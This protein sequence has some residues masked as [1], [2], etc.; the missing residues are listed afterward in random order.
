MDPL[1]IVS[2]T[3]SHSSSNKD[4][5]IISSHFFTLVNSLRGLLGISSSYIFDIFLIGTCSPS[6]SLSNLVNG[7]FSLTILGSINA[8][9]CWYC[10][11]FFFVSLSHFPQCGYFPILQDLDQSCI[12]QPVPFKKMFTHHC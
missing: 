10:S 2:K 11:H 8:C 1:C 4:L 12:F 9:N 5:P 3:L 6:N 7:L